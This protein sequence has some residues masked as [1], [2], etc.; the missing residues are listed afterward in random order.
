M[1]A[2]REAVRVARVS[3]AGASAAALLVITAA[4]AI[5]ACVLA[6]WLAGEFAPLFTPRQQSWFVAAA[7]VFAGLEVI[8][9]DAPPAPKEPTQS[10]GALALVL[11]AGVLADAS[12][13]VILSLAVATGAPMLVAAG[14]A[15]AVAAVM[16]MAALMGE[17][18]QKL[19]RMPLRW[20][21]GIVLL[22]S[23]AII[24]FAPPAALQ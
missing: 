17:D 10:L 18:W 19:P 12:G 24:G 13:L 11:F 16:G 6:A 14:G 15:L 22:A 20:G 3:A 7:L 23:G 2:G 9:L 8:F 5:G 1:L 4:V 21:V